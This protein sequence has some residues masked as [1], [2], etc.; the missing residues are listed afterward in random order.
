VDDQVARAGEAAAK[1]L[2]HEG[3]LA[4]VEGSAVPGGKAQN[5]LALGPIDVLPSRTARASKFGLQILGGNNQAGT[6]PQS[7]HELYHVPP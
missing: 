4:L 6:N 7:L 2:Q 5:H 3:M 1:S